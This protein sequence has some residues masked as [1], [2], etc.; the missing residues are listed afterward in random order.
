MAAVIDGLSTADDQLRADG[1]R[2]G[3]YWFHDSA[4]RT[5]QRIRD[6]PEGAPTTVGDLALAAELPSASLESKE[7]RASELYDRPRQQHPATLCVTPTRDLHV[8]GALA[9][10]AARPVS[11]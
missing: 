11:G 1:L 7:G 8:T 4:D 2:H 6:I 10:S 5:L 9:T 3:R